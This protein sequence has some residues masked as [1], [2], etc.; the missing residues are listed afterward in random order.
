M[1]YF[2]DWMRKNDAS[3]RTIRH[4]EGAITG[5]ITKWA[6]DNGIITTSLADVVNLNDF[7]ALSARIKSLP[8]FQQNDLDGH[9]MYSCALNKYAKYLKDSASNAIEN[10]I[11]AIIESE[12]ISE[13][14]KSALI[15]TRIG[16]G[17]FRGKLINYWK[18]CSV[19]GFPE[20]NLLVASHIKPWAK[21]NNRE[22]M[23]VFNGLLLLP[24]IDRTF[25]YGYIS[26]GRDGKILIAKSLPDP[27]L[28]GIRKDMRVNLA[29]EHEQYLKHHRNSRYRG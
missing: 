8:V 13:T 6:S 12:S 29:S 16:Q 22:R 19:T 7:L 21:S 25:E 10:D 3:E 24:N 18:K 20:V 27:E 23:D 15:K 5:S 2:E 9:N 17:T 11:D 4:Y 28:A 1:S 14:E 26:F